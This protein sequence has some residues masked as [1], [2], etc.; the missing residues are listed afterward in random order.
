MSLPAIKQQAFE[1]HDEW[2]RN[3]LAFVE[4]VWPGTKLEPFQQEGLM[5]LAEVGRVSVR[6]GHGVGKSAMNALAA[7]WMM[8]T[9]YPC[10]VPISAP[11]AHQLEDVLR[12]ELGAWLSNAPAGFRDQFD[13]RK[14]RLSL[15]AAP[16]SSF[17]AFRTGNRS[18]PEAL[19]GFH[20]ENLLFILDEASG[21]DDVVFEV[22]EGALST[23]DARVLMTGNPTRV[24][25]YFF[26]SHHSMRAHFYT[27]HVPCSDSSRVAPDYIER[28]KRFGVDSN[29][30]R[31]RVDGTFPTSEDDA[32]ISLELLEAAVAREVKQVPGPVIWG[33]DV[34]RFGDDRSALAK[35][36]V[37]VLHGKVET[38]T[39]LDTMQVAGWWHSEYSQA[40]PAPE[41]ILIDSIGLG[42]GVVDRLK[43]QGLPVSGVN[44]SERPSSKAQ[45]QR[46]RDELWWQAR[47][48]FEARDCSIP[49]D[50]ELIGELST[51][52][53][54]IGSNGKIEIWSKLKVKKE[55]G[56]PSPDCAD[57]FVHTFAI[58]RHG[59][60]KWA[61]IKYD[62][63]G[64]I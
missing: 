18:N 54:G 6:S 13:L 43:E 23:P 58:E 5:A 2:R 47:E 35:R 31:V 64:I 36:Q 32:V 60:R 25:G 52:K 21:I 55:M 29:I 16:D 46:Y 39:Q 38:R 30:Y 9:H 57:A 56:L 22:A 59:R 44:V 11:T 41:A 37:N 42:A 17:A 10:K 19:Q 40:H 4:S 12:P 51:M 26:D 50:E 48:W 1:R 63:R 28:M 15:R 49:N 27:M 3:P 8:A 53:Y 45:F 33:G 20:A 24:S 62:N 14:D 34:A 61:P 7:L